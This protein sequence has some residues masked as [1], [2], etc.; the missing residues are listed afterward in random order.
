M[1]YMQLVSSIVA[2][3][4]QAQSVASEANAHKATLDADL[5]A[6]KK[7]LRA[8]YQAR[9]KARVEKVAEQEAQFAQESIERL[10]AGLEQD[11][12]SI[13]ALY[14]ANR[15]QWAEELF[16]KIVGSQG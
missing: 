10:N 1:E 14:Q 16:R 6:E 15:D 3:E 8:S 2:A 13:E 9:A 7:M 5:A 11:M 12:A 4:R